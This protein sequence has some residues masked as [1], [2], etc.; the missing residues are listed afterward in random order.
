MLTASFC[1]D[2]L[3]VLFDVDVDA[4]LLAFST[5][6]APAD[7]ALQ[8]PVTVGVADQR[9]PGVALTRVLAASLVARTQHVRVDSVAEVTIA[10]RPRDD[11]HDNLTKLLVVTRT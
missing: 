4:G 7:Y 11:G 3:D 8:P 2:P 9:T 10:L 1:V 5:A 6:D